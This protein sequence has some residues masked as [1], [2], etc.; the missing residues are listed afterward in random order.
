VKETKLL[1]PLNTKIE[2]KEK[3]KGGKEENK[4]E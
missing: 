1:K 4:E 3:N 2:N